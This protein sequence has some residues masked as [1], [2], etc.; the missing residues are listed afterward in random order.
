MAKNDAHT[1]I[2]AVVGT[3]L[4]WLPILAPILFS[5]VRFLES[6]RFM[7]DYL[8]PAE[9]FLLVL[10]G[11]G[12]LT[13]AAKRARSQVRWFAWML[14]IGVGLLIGGQALAVVTGLASGE[15]EPTG[16]QWFL[17]LAAIAGYTITVIGMGIGGIQLIKNLFV[18]QNQA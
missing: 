17:V 8:M 16:W 6:G 11:G 15:I 13:W 14:G 18:Q 7:F 2:L 3:G 12:L 5:L 10:V 1:K 4:V 9:G